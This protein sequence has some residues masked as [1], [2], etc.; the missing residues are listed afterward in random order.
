VTLTGSID[1][2][3]RDDRLCYDPVSVPLSWTVTLNPLDNQR[4]RLQ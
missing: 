4:A 2:Q 3:A 1:Y